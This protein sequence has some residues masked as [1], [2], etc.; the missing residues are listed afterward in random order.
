[1][2]VFAVVWAVIFLR[3]KPDDVQQPAPIAEMEAEEESEAALLA[4]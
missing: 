4:R 2:I 3:M 1:M